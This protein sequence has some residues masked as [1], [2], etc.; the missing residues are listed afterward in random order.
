MTNLNAAQ[1]KQIAKE[2]KVKN[3][4]TKKRADLV[5]EIAEIKG[6][7]NETPE[8]IEFLLAGGEIQKCPASEFPLPKPEKETSAMI[9]QDKPE[10][11]KPRKRPAKKTAEK[12]TA[13]KKQPQEGMVTLPDL[14]KELGVE[15]RI[16][17][18]KLRTAK[19]EKPGSTWAWEEG[20]KE[21][22]EVKELLK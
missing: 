22:D 6:W 17:R 12:K 19:F 3:W 5:T 14:C 11:K 15:G 13:K 2:L 16:A 21:I 1:V 18:R 7:S 4:W 9:A 8:I 20:A 10:K